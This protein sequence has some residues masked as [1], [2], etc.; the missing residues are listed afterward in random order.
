MAPYSCI[1]LK[2]VIE[3][4]V[5]PSTAIPEE[6]PS[7]AIPEEHTADVT[8]TRVTTD[9]EECAT[10]EVQF[11]VH[12]DCSQP[13]E[14]VALVG[15]S[16]ALGSW[17]PWQAIVCTT[18]AEEFPIWSSPIV[19]VP[20]L[21]DQKMEFKLL[22]QGEGYVN[23]EKGENHEV[24]VPEHVQDDEQVMVKCGWG[25]AE[26]SSSVISPEELTSAPLEDVADHSI[27]IETEIKGE[28]S[29]TLITFQEVQFLVHCDCTKL[30]EIVAIVGS[31]PALGSWDASQAI[32]CDVSAE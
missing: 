32:A 3:F 20:V 26:V 25:V 12:C 2:T 9:S 28:S 22:L 14:V 16:P 18:T 30:G 11:H 10:H 7:A 1:A 5:A 6:A 21:H 17:D 29:S 24:I 19:R 4:D 23:W 8:V 13:G 15:G 27:V 31:D